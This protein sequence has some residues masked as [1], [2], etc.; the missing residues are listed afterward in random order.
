MLRKSALLLL[1]VLAVGGCAVQTVS[2]AAPAT[3]PG[4]T[5]AAGAPTTAPNNATAAPSGPTVYN[6]GDTITVQQNGSDYAKI[7]ISDVSSA[8]SYLGTYGLNDNPQTKGNV[9]IAAKVTYLAL[10]D[11]VTYNP[12]DWS[13]FCA[14]TAI[15]NTAFV[16]NG[17]TP[18]LSSG[19]LPNGKNA[20]GFVT[21]EVPPKG[22]V[23]MYYG[24]QF[25]GTPLFDVV[26][27]AS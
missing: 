7:T 11:G 20:S 13:V 6:T 3:A 9:F 18:E 27:R 23:D 24:G 5:T 25:G 8:P 19:T 10:T 14:G 21:Y 17:P 22:E 2:T 15:S 12:Y 16:M 4:A 1:A 26:I